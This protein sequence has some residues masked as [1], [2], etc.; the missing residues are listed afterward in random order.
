ML[1]LGGHHNM[2]NHSLKWKRTVV[3]N[4]VGEGALRVRTATATSLTR[5]PMLLIH[6]GLA[7]QLSAL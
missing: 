1:R 5:W 6:K 2:R 3:P 4:A 7:G